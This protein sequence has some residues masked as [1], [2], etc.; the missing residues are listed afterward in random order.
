MKPTTKRQRKLSPLER[1]LLDSMKQANSGKVQPAS[2]VVRVEIAPGTFR[3]SA[4]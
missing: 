1:A 3:P 4:K 2:N